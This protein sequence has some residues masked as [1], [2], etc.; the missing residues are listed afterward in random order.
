MR[1]LEQLRRFVAPATN[2]RVLVVN[3]HPDP[4]PA[5]FCAAL[6]ES[7][8]DGAR[9]GGA[10]V[11]QL[12]AARVEQD[13]S[14]TDAVAAIAW[15]THFVVIFPLWL[16]GIPS[17]L[18]A[19]FRQNRLKICQSTPDDR[20]VYMIVTMDLPGFLHRK[21]MNSDTGDGLRL[22]GFV[23]QG[24]YFI[25]SVGSLTAEQRKHW[26]ASL[27]ERGRRGDYLS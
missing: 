2:R 4:S 22:A 9:A 6:C 21:T 14:L 27:H 1:L 23:R 10:E 3:G 19:L 5:R 8:S 12:Q 16:D 7:F 11:K 26:L 24:Q 13:P 17:A 20:P 25:G 18:D 15:A